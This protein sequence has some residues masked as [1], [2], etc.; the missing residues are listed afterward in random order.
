MAT[1]KKILIQAKPIND[2]VFFWSPPKNN[3]GPNKNIK[4]Y[5][6]PY[7]CNATKYSQGQDW[8]TT[9][10]YDRVIVDGEQQHSAYVECDYVQ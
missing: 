10:V 3:F 4:K 8:I 6:K 9:Y 1:T 7:F 2:V 5:V